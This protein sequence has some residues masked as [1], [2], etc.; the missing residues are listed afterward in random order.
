MAGRTVSAMMESEPPEDKGET[1]LAAGGLAAPVRVSLDRWGVPLIEAE[2]EADLFYGLGWMHARD[3]RFQ[4]ELL[5]MD[6]LGRLRELIGPTNNET[7]LRL[8]MFS[9]A[10][11]FREEAERNLAALS[12]RDRA[13]MESYVA[14]VN[15]CTARERIPFE[16]KVLG[17]RPDAWGAVDVLAIME[18]VSFGFC[19]NWET[20]L[21]RL[22]IMDY[23]LATGSTARRALSLWPVRVDWPPHLIGK[24]PA[25]DPFAGVP[26]V[27]PELLSY[28]EEHA[29]ASRRTAGKGAPGTPAA[30][31]RDAD[32]A[33]SIAKNLEG[34]LDFS[35]FASNNWAVDGSW[36]GT[37][38]AAL[39]MD[40][41]MP[42]SLPPLTYLA[43]LRL[44]GAEGNYEVTGASLAGLPAIPF[45]TNGSVAWG[46]TSNWADITD[47]YVEKPA[48]GEADSYLT[49]E[50]AA[51][52]RLKEVEFLVRM[53]DGSFRRESRKIRSTRHGVLVNDFVDRL[54]GDFPL[55]A[56]KKPSTF[57]TSMD[58]LSK[59]Y[60]SGNVTEARK[61]LS[62]F[63]AMIGHW[64]LAD[65]GGNIGYA[66]AVPLPDRK[67][68][69]GTFPVPGWTNAYEW[70]DFIPE[71]RLP[72]VENPPEHFLGTANN[73]V[74]QPE[75]T[76]YPINF[77][78]EKPLRI[79][80]IV[81]RLAGGNDGRPVS[82]QMR[83]L[84]MDGKDMSYIRLRPFLR[85]VLEPLAE[86]KDTLLSRAAVVLLDWNGEVRPQSVA[87]SLYSGWVSTAFAVAMR[88]EVAPVTL[89]YLQG[90]FNT[91]AL[92]FP[93]L[94][95]A[96]HPAWDDRG[97]AEKEEAL[98]VARDA[99]RQTVAAL[100]ARHGGDIAQWTWTRVAPFVIKHTFGDIGVM[101]RLNRG[102]LPDRGDTATVN[103]HRYSRQNAAYSPVLHGPA[104]RFTMDFADPASSRMSIPG[105]QSGRPG[106]PHYDDILPLYLKGDGIPVA[107]DP[108][109]LRRT[110]RFR[111]L[112]QP[113]P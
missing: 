61:A 101:G 77:E 9:R 104:L 56:L 71:D 113:A 37:G 44:R 92:I 94:E 3:R 58:S 43:R 7:I 4:M 111:I 12:A 31:P 16:F 53:E 66:A 57:G 105:G 14:G 75:S 34:I 100:R 27:A 69:L 41:H 49:P 108:E 79:E 93:I 32:P 8:E 13:V 21:A 97:T 48:E 52:F 30:G 84:Q 20:E 24:K 87:P 28:L 1:T 6:S 65:A 81:E 70:G 74:V 25:V 80:R 60:R 59:L 107:M 68:W 82:E 95:D 54:P 109:E 55:V 2:G 18:M 110:A 10:I 51:A 90:H 23:Q 91:D 11:G 15:A 88:D 86:E 78:G 96:D 106:S 50:G 17:Y 35:S 98:S 62:G 36:T 112:L 89:A 99:F 39:A 40:P 73:Q 19:K 38:R 64:A 5:R 45:G 33:A 102:P 63:T 76:G 29:R 67:G 26:E 83:E 42:H 72:W 22:E 47:L 103:M 46:P 85:R